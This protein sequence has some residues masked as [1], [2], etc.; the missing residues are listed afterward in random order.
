M[1]KRRD[2]IKNNLRLVILSFPLAL[3]AFVN[4]YFAFVLQ[5]VIDITSTGDIKKLVS[6]V[7][8]SLL[9]LLMDI[10]VSLLVK[11]LSG[12]FIQSELIKLK[13]NKVDHNLR[14]ACNM[15]A[16]SS[17]LTLDT[18]LIERD[19]FQ[20]KINVIFYA[21]QIIFGLMAIIY[22][23]FALTVGIG[24]VTLL[25]IFV[26]ILLKH[27]VKK[28]KENFLNESE[29]YTEFL[30]EVE[31]G[32]YIIADYCL[33]ALFSKRH[34]IQNK[35]LENA[36]FKSKFIESSVDVITSNLGMLTFIAA[37]GIGSYYV[38]LG[39]MTFG[40]MI[41]AIQLLN[42]IIQPLN[43][44]SHSLNRMNSTHGIL[45]EYQRNLKETEDSLEDVYSIE[46]I[47]FKNVSYIYPD[48]TE[49]IKNISAFFEKGKSY[50]LD[51][52][53]GSGKS[54]I[55]KL[56]AGDCKPDCGEILI[57]GTNMNNLSI[58]SVKSRLG[59][60]RQE[61]FLF[62]DD[63]RNNITM[64]SDYSSSDYGTALKDAALE[65]VTDKR[66]KK[67]IS[68]EKGLSGGQRQRIGIARAILK[69]PDVLIMDEATSSLDYHNAE[70]VLNNILKKKSGIKIFVTH[71]EE[72][73]T[74]FDEII[75]IKTV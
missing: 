65:D 53:S 66:L 54:T 27:K 2:F 20:Q 72:L 4:V 35:E 31:N 73:K 50:V 18:E 56:L 43:Y 44:I 62:K 60:M 8:F 6:A 22:I 42:S 74:N 33:S 12:K 46:S 34:D 30:K 23:S 38:I 7:V 16:L 3:S 59:I 14:H 32:K 29:K 49:G 51:G 19:F 36:R 71:D 40:L 61:V 45:K 47:E 28:K 63:I 13:K 52:D 75:S 68:N 10:L 48:G 5:K 69:N 17:R 26:P 24:I 9:Y 11:Y 55:L 67:N 25:P 58:A 57:N 39:K 70:K 37:L 64:W 21:L 15:N 41:A 1:K